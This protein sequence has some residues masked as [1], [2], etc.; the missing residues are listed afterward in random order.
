MKKLQKHLRAFE[1]R[2][3]GTQ[4]VQTVIMKY[5]ISSLC[6]LKSPSSDVSKGKAAEK[7]EGGREARVGA[8]AV[9]S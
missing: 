5:L 3:P 1:K 8:G 9:K 7:V 6:R 4:S 2:L